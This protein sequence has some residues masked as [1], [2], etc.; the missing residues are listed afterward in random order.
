MEL[1]LNHFSV[2]LFQIE[3]CTKKQQVYAVEKSKQVRSI[4]RSVELLSSNWQKHCFQIKLTQ[5]C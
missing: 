5:Y 4:Q 3:N 2:Q 1:K